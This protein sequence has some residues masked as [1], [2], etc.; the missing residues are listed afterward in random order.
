[1]SKFK[2]IEEGRVGISDMSKIMGGGVNPGCYQDTYK[3]I[4]ECPGY[5]VYASC[6]IYYYSC[7]TNGVVSCGG[8]TGGHRGAP[9]GAGLIATSPLEIDSTTVI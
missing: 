3:T 8:A 7:N 9:G 1:M 2:I 5:A 4:K 6:P